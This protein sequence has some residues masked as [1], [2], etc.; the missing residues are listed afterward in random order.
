MILNK[1]NKLFAQFPILLNMT[2]AMLKKHLSLL[3]DATEFGK[4]KVQMTIILD[5]LNGTIEKK[6]GKK[7]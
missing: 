1:K 4:K 7:Y 3:W 2:L 6:T 5:R